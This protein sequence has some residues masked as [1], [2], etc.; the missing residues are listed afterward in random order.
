MQLTFRLS[1][2]MRSLESWLFRAFLDYQSTYC[3]LRKLK[4]YIY[5]FVI[6]FIYLFLVAMGLHCCTQVFSSCGE[7][8]LLFTVVH[9]LLFVVVFLVAEHRL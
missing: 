5:I 9:G 1:N 2:S 3:K 8:G 4:I 7:Q 6:Y